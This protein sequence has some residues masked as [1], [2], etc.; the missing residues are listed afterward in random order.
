MDYI[1]SIVNNLIEIFTNPLR[2]R[3]LLSI[4]SAV[5]IIAAI[6]AGVFAA[7]S[8]SMDYRREN[9]IYTNKPYKKRHGVSDI[10]KV[11]FKSLNKSL[12]ILERDK[13]K[14]EGFADTATLAV[15]VGLFAF[16]C[17][18]F[19]NHQVLLAILL[20][21]VLFKIIAKVIGLLVESEGEKIRAV[22]PYGIDTIIRSMSRN[23]DLKT[24]LYDASE[25]LDE[26][27][28]SMFAGMSIRMAQQNPIRVLEKFMEDNN[29]IW[30]YSLSFTLISY[31]E[32]ASK[33]ETVT[34]LRRLK[35]VIDKENREKSASKAEKKMTVA[36]NWVL[37]AF[38]VIGFIGNLMMNPQ[39]ESFFF[40]SF[41]GLAAFIV[42]ITLVV[43]SI[44][45]NLLLG[46]G[47][48]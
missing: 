33:D 35:E 9:E 12:T 42:G 6:C 39:A 3:E 44:F 48:G 40:A 41:G 29:N 37:C 46:R 25:Q 26:P 43:L 17:F 34:Q 21:I 30:V 23:D 38:A 10:A 4:G 15:V 24:V 31:L 7:Y 27:L 32:D 2:V 36:V 14:K 28:K 16:G 19:L 1:N 11:W 13:G 47:R 8:C 45:S 5:I 22:L 18:L 20:P